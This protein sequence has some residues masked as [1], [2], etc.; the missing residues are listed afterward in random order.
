M[1]KASLIGHVI[2]VFAKFTSRTEI[3]AD[4]TIRNFSRER[5]YLG[6]SD[7]RFISDVYFGTIKNYLRLEAI[8][9]DALQTQSTHPQLVI[10]AYCIIFRGD[11]PAEMRKI[12][13]TLSGDLAR[14]YPLEIFEKFADRALEDKRMQE[15]SPTQRLAILYSYPE[16]FVEHLE[17][18]Y[19]PETEVVLKSLNE[20]ATTNLRVNTTVTTREKLQK[21]LKEAGVETT[22]GTL[23]DDALILRRRM[24]VWDLKPFKE[25]QFEIQD[26]ASQLIAPFAAIS[27]NRLRILDA[28]AGAGGKALHFSSLL[29]GGG[30]I[31]ATDVDPYKLEELKK[32]T[33]RSNAQNIRIVKPDKYDQYLGT[34]TFGTFDVVLLDVPCSGTGTLRR[35]P[36]IKWR[37]SEQMHNELIEKQ[38]HILEHNAPYVKEKGVL[39]Y[40]TCSLLKSE[41]EEQI[42]WFLSLHP[43]F[44]LEAT[45]RT[46]PEQER[47]DGFFVARLRR[48]QESKIEN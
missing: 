20:E 25:G 47:C 38:R 29:R 3:P 32:R 42:N 39:L 33:I 14:N 11:T 30:E 22:F 41:G 24:N 35:N 40:S 46:H 31:F 7:R 9:L 27:S 36:S 37:L 8:T 5:K 6:S 12:I 28:C 10:A 1:T 21:V 4:I 34:K 48:R 16:W 19:G 26:E 23:S 17:K 45:R 43:E 13:S 15:L 2:E 18:E 44:T